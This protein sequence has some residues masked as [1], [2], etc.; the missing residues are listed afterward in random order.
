LYCA[1]TREAPSGGIGPLG[2]SR[3]SRGQQGHVASGGEGCSTKR[4]MHKQW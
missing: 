3:K 4:Y 1:S 2:D